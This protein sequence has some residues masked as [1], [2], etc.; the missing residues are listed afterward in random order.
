MMYNQTS[1]NTY[2]VRKGALMS[3]LLKKIWRECIIEECSILETK[4]EKELSKIVI[5]ARDA[6]DLILNEKEKEAVDLYVDN[7]YKMQ[8]IYA[9]R[10]FLKGCETIFKLFVEAFT[11]KEE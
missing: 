4:E 3:K 1:Y 9:E 5:R 2:V 6:M 8:T 7:I 10:A 11:M